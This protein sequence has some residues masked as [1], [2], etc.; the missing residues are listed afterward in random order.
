M[1]RRGA[2]LPEVAL[3]LRHRSTATT[4]RYAKVDQRALRGLARPWPG[5][6]R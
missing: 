1:L 6:T 2:S 3:V 5:S 4:S